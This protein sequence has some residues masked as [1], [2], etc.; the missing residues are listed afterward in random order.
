MSRLDDMALS[1][2]EQAEK[3]YSELDLSDMA[4]TPNIPHP[5]FKDGYLLG[6]AQCLQD[7]SDGD[8]K[9]EGGEVRS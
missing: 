1:F 8:I 7:I 9:V 3:A 4:L 6:Y 5:L 2:N